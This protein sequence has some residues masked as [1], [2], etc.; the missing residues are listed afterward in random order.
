MGISEGVAAESTE[1]ESSTTQTTEEI[2]QSETKTS[3][4]KKK[5]SEETTQSTS[6]EESHSDVIEGDNIGT[7]IIGDGTQINPFEVYS[8]TDLEDAISSGNVDPGT[9]IKYVQLKNDILISRDNTPNLT[10]NTNIELNGIKDPAQLSSPENYYTLNY[11]AAVTGTMIKTG[12]ASSGLNVT[13]KNLNIGSEQYP[14]NTNW[15]FVRLYG[16]NHTLNVENINYNITQ[17]GSQPF[18]SHGQDCT[19]NISGTNLYN[20]PNYTA[21]SGGEFVEGYRYV[22]FKKG[23]N[24]KI[25]NY[26]AEYTAFFYMYTASKLNVTVE[27][28]ANVDIDSARWFM[29]YTGRTGS[30]VP[31]QRLTLEKNAN[32]TYKV[33]D[34][35]P[36]MRNEL[37]EG[38]EGVD[39]YMYEGSSF[40]YLT[41]DKP[42]NIKDG[43]YVQAFDPASM[44][45][46]KS[47]DAT[48]SGG[49]LVGNGRANNQVVVWNRGRNFYQAITSNNVINST[50]PSW[51]ADPIN[52]S[53][54][55]IRTDG[56]FIG[57][58]WIE[59]LPSMSLDSVSATS[60]VGN[61]LSR[62]LSNVYGFTTGLQGEWT[63]KTEYVL[64]KTPYSDSD[65]RLD[66]TGLNEVFNAQDKPG[67]VY[68]FTGTDKDTQGGFEDLLA[69]DYYIYGRV[70]ATRTSDNYSSSTLWVTNTGLGVELQ[71]VNVP[72]H[73]AT[74][75]PMSMRFHSLEGPVVTR[76]EDTYH[77]ESYS[78]V[79]TYIKMTDVSVGDNSD[80]TVSLVE[81]VTED[82][83]F[84]KL[85]LLATLPSTSEVTWPAYSKGNGQV[86][87][88][89][90]YFETD[91]KAEIK[92]SGD[93]SGPY[94]SVK[95]VNYNIKFNISDTNS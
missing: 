67:G 71:P 13:F 78:N 25:I 61:K 46:G 24:T 5:E 59:Y 58:D 37:I 65:G 69:Q 62:V 41:R 55:F 7:Q 26:T 90:P 85:D 89:S 35:F 86:L 56:G 16:P 84:L 52:N 50:V 91:A 40:K 76:K 87:Q 4:S 8:T 83:N 51:H 53:V 31:R 93:Y 19:L 17:R 49:A 80:P 68:T 18:K 2:Q 10:I 9:G 48:Y 88:L 20:S 54:Y 95:K 66:Y 77:V 64:S 30:G 81:N 45:I 36:T 43:L 57:K 63:F 60:E 38:N 47:D 14:N 72:Q 74:V 42:I 73:I 92:F 6:S 21:A 79:P 75:F 12:T 44:Y 34:N 94:Y 1:V 27:E 11:S 32:F 15:G 28:D 33:R 29:F 23:S 82:A 70:T 3:Q 22:N 39:L